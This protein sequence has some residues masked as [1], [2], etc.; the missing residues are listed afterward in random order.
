M[1]NEQIEKN[2]RQRKEMNKIKV[3]EISALESI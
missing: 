3:E 1:I 2:E